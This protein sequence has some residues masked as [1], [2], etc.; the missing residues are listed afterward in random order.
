MKWSFGVA[1]LFGIDVHLHLTFVAF[2][3]FIGLGNWLVDGS[4]HAA[5]IGLLFFIGLFVCVLLHEFGH[6]LMARRYAIGTAEI[7]LLPIGG[8][9]RLD[10]MPEKPLQEIAVALAGPAVNL[11]IAGLL[12]AW[13]AF[14]DSW[15][16]WSEL[17]PTAGNLPER[18]LVANLF[19]AAFN[20]LPAFPMDGGRVLRGLLGLRFDFGRSTRIAATVG[21]SMAIL[22]GI[23]GLWGNPMLVVIALFVWFGAA[24]ERS[25]L[26]MKHALQGVTVRTA[27]IADLRV[28]T[29][30][31][32]LRDATHYLLDSSQQ[33]FPVLR[34]S[35]LV[36]IL[37]RQR[38]FAG[39]RARGP[40]AKVTEY[41]ETDVASAAPHELLDNALARLKPDGCTT[42]AVSER[43][44]FLGLVTAET[45]GELCMLHAALGAHTTPPAT[46]P[47]LLPRRDPAHSPDSPRWASPAT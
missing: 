31:S 3:L 19:L 10:R 43:G 14:T 7:T 35:A 40:E 5:M 26:E 45:V 21:Q 34:G 47:L 16:P 33:E 9:A 20:L 38:L 12:A 41:I 1:R 23:A 29:A 4:A 2:L 36:G 30:D 24:Q 44:E 8:L 18:L 28:L 27:M 22:F 15:Q 17:S 39:L 13:L 32:T 6:A 42:L 11:V 37:T 25:A 46:S